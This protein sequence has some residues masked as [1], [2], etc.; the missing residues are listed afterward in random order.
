[1][2][3]HPHA[4]YLVVPLRGIEFSIIAHLHATPVREPGSLDTLAGQFGLWLTQSDAQRFHSI[5]LGGIHDQT[6]PATA[7]VQ[8]PLAAAE[9]QFA[10]EVIQL[11]LLRS[12][13]VFI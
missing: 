9:A 1:M 7:N 3:K 10:T 8:E 2:L 4:G 12:I 11:P 6:A 5:V 13:Q